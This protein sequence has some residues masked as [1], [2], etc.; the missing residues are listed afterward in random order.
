MWK[1]K[2]KSFDRETTVIYSRYDNGACF[3]FTVSYGNQ[4][5]FPSKRVYR[6]EKRL[7]REKRFLRMNP[8]KQTVQLTGDVNYLRYSE[9]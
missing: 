5:F 4:C 2:R 9:T 1:G 6:G 8:G 3:C 7:L